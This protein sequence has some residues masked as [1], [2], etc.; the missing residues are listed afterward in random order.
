MT[1]SPTTTSNAPLTVT[2]D[3]EARLGREALVRAE[4][5]K[6]VEPTRAEPGCIRYD[7]HEDAERPNRFFFY[8][9]WESRDLWQRHMNADH[10]A[11]YLAA[12]DGAVERFDV[13]QLH[14]V[15]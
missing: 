6:L 10:I 11:A 1:T 8:E 12:T 15:D 5:E 3:I 13:S 2:A 7:L 9:T 4:L 14:R